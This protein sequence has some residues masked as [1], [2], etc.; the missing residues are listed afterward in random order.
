MTLVA[1]LRP[2]LIGAVTH[3]P[4]ARV[5]LPAGRH[6]IEIPWS[7]FDVP[8]AVA[9]GLTLQFEPHAPS[10]KSAEVTVRQVALVTEEEFGRR[11]SSGGLEID[12]GRPP[13]FAVVSGFVTA[14]GGRPLWL[15]QD[16]PAQR[17]APRVVGRLRILAPGHR[18]AVRL[19]VPTAVLGSALADQPAGLSASG[20]HPRSGWMNLT[21]AAANDGVSLVLPD[22]MVGRTVVFELRAAG[23]PPAWDTRFAAAAATALLAGVLALRF[24]RRLAANRKV[25]LMVVAALVTAAAGFLWMARPRPNAPPVS[26]VYWPFTDGEASVLGGDPDGTV[27]PTLSPALIDPIS[28]S[29]DLKVSSQQSPVGGDR[30]EVPFADFQRGRKTVFGA[31]VGGFSGPGAS[32]TVDC[33]PAGGDGPARTVLRIVTAVPAGTYAGVWMENLLPGGIDLAQ[34]RE[35]RFDVRSV[36][37]QATC[38]LELKRGHRIL[39]ASRVVVPGGRWFRI[40]VPLTD[41]IHPDAMS[42]GFD[43]IVWKFTEPSNHLLL[44]NVRFVK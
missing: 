28:P 12:F 30:E 44:G 41:L 40:D 26:S 4:V 27:L 2:R 11:W 21:P 8:A 42:Q 33:I 1:R 5:N 37:V 39:G 23:R 10:H 16:E 15:P 36:G 38:V 9:Y 22:G 32:C 13:E 29:P 35:L 3:G 43:E 34:C 17:A 18:D 6:A 20:F 14:A 24:R 19:K 7:Q 31:R 25:G